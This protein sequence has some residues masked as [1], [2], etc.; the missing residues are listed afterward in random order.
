VLGAM[1]LLIGGAGDVDA[2]PTDDAYVA[3]Y[4]SAI[5]ERE[6][7]VSGPALV[8]RDGVITVAAGDLGGADRPAVESTLGRIRGVRRVIVLSAPTAAA[9]GPTGARGGATPD[10]GQ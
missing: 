4:A 9:G 5:L 6:F 10:D 8:V 2:V 1:L 3:G 7:R